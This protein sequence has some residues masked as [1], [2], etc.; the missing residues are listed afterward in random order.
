MKRKGEGKVWVCD[1]YCGGRFYKKMRLRE[2]SDTL[3]PE[4]SRR[5]KL[6]Q[7]YARGVPIPPDEVPAMAWEEYAAVPVRNLTDFFVIQG[8]FIVSRRFVDTVEPFDL[9]GSTF[10][11][12]ALYRHDRTRR[13]D[14]EYF[15]FNW[16][17]RR[18]CFIPDE[19][20][21]KLVAKGGAM[22]RNVP[23]HV[24]AQWTLC[25]HGNNELAVS[26]D[27]LTG[28]D[29]WVDPLLDFAFFLSG[30]LEAALREAKLIKG[31]SRWRCRIVPAG[32]AEGGHR[33]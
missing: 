5:S 32:E 15:F 24:E 31:L 12:I 25:T 21:T 2:P 33:E 19:E 6:A 4:V 1:S 7:D 8:Y 23:E 28:P 22:R 29:F 27:A 13:M 10:H 30:P 17:S 3:T 16:D 26:A 14:G 9:G 20:G 18:R 11:P